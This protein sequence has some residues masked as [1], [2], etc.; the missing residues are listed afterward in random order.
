MGML[1]E[2]SF[3]SNNSP[4][5]VAKLEFVAKCSFP[6]DV[7]N[8]V[9]LDNLLVSGKENQFRYLQQ[10]TVRPQKLFLTRWTLPLSLT[11]LPFCLWGCS[12]SIIISVEVVGQVGTSDWISRSRS[13]PILKD[14]LDMKERNKVFQTLKSAQFSL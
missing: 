13:L 9:S 2:G 5:V 11:V 14:T 12:W 3:K 8:V 10:K 7:A 6:A 4:K 1:V